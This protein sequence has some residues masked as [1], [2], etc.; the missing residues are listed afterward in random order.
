MQLNRQDN[1]LPSPAPVTDWIFRQEAAAL[2]DQQAQPLTSPSNHVSLPFVNQAAPGESITTASSVT[3]TGPSPGATEHSR[4]PGVTTKPGLDGPPSLR[5]NSIPLPRPRTLGNT[6]LSVEAIDEL[7]MMYVRSCD[8][9]DSIYCIHPSSNLHLCYLQL[10]HALSSLS[11]SHRP[12]QITPRVLS[13]LRASFLVH[14]RRRF[15]T[16]SFSTY[17]PFQASKSRHRSPL[18]DH[19]IHPLLA[20]SRTEFGAALYVA[21]SYK[22]QHCRPYVHAGRYHVADRNTDGTPPCTRCSRVCQGPL[23]IEQS[24][25]CRV[26][27]H[28]ASL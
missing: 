9:S 19:S 22:Q 4:A 5:R 28:M 11:T 23:E 6:V 16:I 7:F 26:V 27:T 21:L 1:Q 17:P 20:C 14:H 24:R 25:V 15:Q 18:E 10:H 2:P 13:V 8:L 3:G 12:W